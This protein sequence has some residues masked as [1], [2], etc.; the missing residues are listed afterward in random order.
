[1][2]SFF[3]VLVSLQFWK[4]NDSWPL[5]NVISP[6]S[7]HNLRVNLRLCDKGITWHEPFWYFWRSILKNVQTLRSLK[8]HFA[9]YA[10]FNFYRITKLTIF[11]TVNIHLDL[12]GYSYNQ[13]SWIGVPASK[14]AR[15]L[16]I[17]QLCDIQDNKTFKKNH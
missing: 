3:K 7:T 10:V 4:I 5:K 1:M 9:C 6:P 17:A 11:W 14:D 2:D 16:H 15:N 12:P 8:F 13:L